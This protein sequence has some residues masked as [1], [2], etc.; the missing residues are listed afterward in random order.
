LIGGFLILAALFFGDGYVRFGTALTHSEASYAWA[1]GD[2][3]LHMSDEQVAAA[4]ARMAAERPAIDAEFAGAWRSFLGALV[5]WLVSL[6]C[7]AWGLRTKEMDASHP[8]RLLG[9]VEIVVAM[10]LAGFGL[11]VFGGVMLNGGIIWVNATLFYALGLYTRRI[12]NTYDGT[13]ATNLLW[14]LIAVFG[15]SWILALSITTSSRY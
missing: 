9:T 1:K 14:A 3:R 5:A 7:I 8:Y 12:T 15:F 13:I 2:H 4:R 10:M 11:V 6:A